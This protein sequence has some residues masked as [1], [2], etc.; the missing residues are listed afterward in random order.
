MPLTFGRLWISTLHNGSDHASPAAFSG[1]NKMCLGSLGSFLYL[2]LD[3]MVGVLPPSIPRS[4]DGCYNFSSKVSALLLTTGCT[5]KRKCF[6]NWCPS[7]TL[8]LRRSEARWTS[9]ER[10]SEKQCLKFSLS[11]TRCSYWKWFIGAAS[12]LQLH[13]IL[14]D[15]MVC[16]HGYTDC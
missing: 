16:C 12:S 1:N 2:W 4:R 14:L 8:P 9:A 5:R 3:W 15:T 11:Y 13:L 10:P 6:P 7:T